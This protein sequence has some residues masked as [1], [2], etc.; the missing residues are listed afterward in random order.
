M[1]TAFL[2]CHLYYSYFCLSTRRVN[3]RVTGTDGS[4]STR[5][6]AVGARSYLCRAHLAPE[7]RCS[8][9]TFRYGYLVTT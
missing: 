8:S 6:I 1:R 2:S 9:R 4:G 5:A 3:K 7:R